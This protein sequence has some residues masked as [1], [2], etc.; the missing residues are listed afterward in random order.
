MRRA[1]Y[2]E[3]LGIPQ[4]INC[5]IKAPLCP[6]SETPFAVTTPTGTNTV[7]NPLGPNCRPLTA[8]ETPRPARG[9]TLRPPNGKA[10]GAPLWGC[11]DPNGC[12]CSVNANDFGPP[13][14][15][16][17]PLYRNKAFFTV[18]G[19]ASN[20]TCQASQTVAMTPNC[21]DCK[22]TAYLGP[23]NP[24]RGIAMKGAPLT[25]SQSATTTQPTGAFNFPAALATPGPENGMRRTTEGSFFGEGPY[26]YSYTP[27]CRFVLG[28]VTWILPCSQLMST[29]LRERVS[30][31]HLRPP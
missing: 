19:S 29:H 30:D 26:L 18:A 11:T 15:K 25:G 7:W 8:G 17:P 16:S 24:Q 4:G 10:P 28:L 1:P 22:T 23:G 12:T 14:D 21:T 3:V 2:F 13:C 31:G 27:G 5:H 6:I 20:A 9:D